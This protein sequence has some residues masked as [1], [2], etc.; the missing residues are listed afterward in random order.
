MKNVEF[1]ICSY[2]EGTIVKEDLMLLQNWIKESP[3]NRDFFNQLKNAWL[4]SGKIGF[5]EDHIENSWRSF[6]VRKDLYAE[7]KPSK[8]LFKISWKVAASWLLFL[9]AGSSLTFVFSDKPSKKA[10][11]SVEVYSPL[12]AR[13][14]I[15]LP[16]GSNVWLNAGTT[17]SYNENYGSDNRTLNLSGEAYFDVAEDKQRPF[18]V[19]TAELIVKALGTKFNVKAYPDEK[20]VAATLEEGIIDVT[21]MK[22]GRNWKRLMLE[23]NQKII[24]LKD[25][26]MID[27]LK[28]NSDEELFIENTRQVSLPRLAENIGVINNVKTELSTSWKDTRWII[29]SEQMGTLIPMLERRF[30]K[31][32]VF[33]DEDLKTYRFSGTI[34]NETV[35]QFMDL[36][37]LTAPLNYVI[38]KEMIVL[39]LDKKSKD[40]FGKIITPG[41]KPK[42]N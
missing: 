42:K 2:L 26:Q 29:E 8:S 7:S 20:A 31:R 22:E 25:G 21:V 11:R 19:K 24:V 10:V 34:E 39:S 17:L 23:E 41:Y 15:K 6:N 40:D 35:E 12:G 28:I 5:T 33:N 38:D 30:N 37:T 16:D 1:L 4:V 9:L 13:T 14:F 32:I 18:V 27:S 36:L 3:E